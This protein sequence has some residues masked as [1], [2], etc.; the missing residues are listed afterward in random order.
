[1]EACHVYEK[2]ARKALS[3]SEKAVSLRK[4]KLVGGIY[5]PRNLMTL[6]GTCHTFFDTHKLGIHPSDL[7]WIVTDKLRKGRVKSTSKVAYADIHG[8]SVVF[9]S[10]GGAPPTAGLRDRSRNFAAAN[11]REDGEL[12]VHYCHF[13][14]STF[15]GKK[16]LGTMSSHVKGCRTDAKKREADG[17]SVKRVLPSKKVKAKKLAVKKKAALPKE[18][19]KASI[20]GGKR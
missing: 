12:T 13:C 8:K 18:A 19:K 17:K 5:Y 1:M 20:K 2:K 15:K 16:A 14:P 6:C 7:R 4:L 9:A 11:A 10:K 3:A